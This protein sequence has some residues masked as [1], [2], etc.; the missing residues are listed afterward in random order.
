MILQVKQSVHLSMALGPAFPTFPFYL[1]WSFQNLRKI[2]KACI[3]VPIFQDGKTET[4][5]S[6]ELF[7]NLQTELEA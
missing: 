4:S 1:L 7:T 3:I 5:K 6:Q 2:W